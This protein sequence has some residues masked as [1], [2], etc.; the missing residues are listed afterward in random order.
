LKVIGDGGSGEGP[1]FKKVLPPK[2]HFHTKAANPQIVGTAVIV[3][4]LC[5]G[6]GGTVLLEAIDADIRWTRA[7]HDAAGGERGWIHANDQPWAALYH[8]GELPA[9]LA[10][11]FA[12]GLY[13]ARGPR[14]RELKRSCLVVVLTVILGPGIL[15]NGILKNHWGRPRPVEVAAFGGP[16]DYQRLWELGVPGRGK[17]FPCGHCAMA[18]SLVSAAAFH[19]ARPLA[20]GLVVLGG[21]LYGIAMGAARIAQGGHFPTDV[22]WSGVL[23]LAIAAA[24]YY[25]VFRIPEHTAARQSPVRPLFENRFLT[26]ALLVILGLV[27]PGTLSLDRWPFYRETYAPIDIPAGVEVVQLAVPAAGGASPALRVRERSRVWLRV[28]SKGVGW[29]WARL[30]YDTEISVD[31]PLMKVT[32]NA[33]KRGFLADWSLQGKLLDPAEPGNKFLDQLPKVMSDYW[34]P[35]L[36][37]HFPEDPIN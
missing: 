24:L 16:W 20:F 30:D 5:L 15:V 4:L 35:D 36:A 14:R 32:L 8:Y 34:R 2:T 27:L 6:L 12:A 17:S 11:L 23:V 26:S 9:V 10:A 28:T 7:F 1:S 37:T 21:V 22:L 18:F 33:A 25:L 19:T 3:G 29:P 13:I 31:K